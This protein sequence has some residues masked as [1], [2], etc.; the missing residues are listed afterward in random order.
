[1]KVP[2]LA[3]F[4]ALLVLLAAD[5]AMAN[6]TIAHLH[7]R[8]H[9]DSHGEGRRV[10]AVDDH[11]DTL[12]VINRVLTRAGAEVRTASSAVEGLSILSDWL[13][14]LIL[15]DMGMPGQDGYAFIRRVR[16]LPRPG[17]SRVKAVA[18]TAF[19]RESDRKAAIEAGFD[20]H[21]AKP[22]E[23]GVLFRKVAELVGQK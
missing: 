20:D 18:L 22:V 23:A 15:P 2:L 9:A 4:L 1:M 8:T 12:R 16:A 5:V 3:G 14:D 21:L 10:L 17:M 19:A 13:P 11:D 6:R 7:E